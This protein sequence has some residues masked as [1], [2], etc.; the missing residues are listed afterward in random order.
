MAATKFVH[1]NKVKNQLRFYREDGR[2]YYWDFG[3]KH[4]Y[5]DKAECWY[6]L[7]GK[8]ITKAPNGAIVFMRQTYNSLAVKQASGDLTDEEYK[9]MQY[10]ELVAL[11]RGHNHVHSIADY[12]NNPRY[13][14]GCD[15]YLLIMNVLESLANMGLKITYH[16]VHNQAR[17]NLVDVTYKFR[18]IIT[19]HMDADEDIDPKTVVKEFHK[20]YNNFMKRNPDAKEMYLLDIAKEM[21]YLKDKPLYDMGF[22]I[23]FIEALKDSYFTIEQIAKYSKFMLMCY[24]EWALSEEVRSIYS[25]GKISMCR[26]IVYN[27]K[28]TIKYCERMDYMPRKSC[29][30]KK[31]IEHI[32]EMYRLWCVREDAKSLKELN[33]EQ[34]L[35]E[36]DELM[37]TLPTCAQ[38]LIDCGNELNNCVG[39]FGYWEKMVRNHTCVIVFV[40]R[41]SDPD[42]HYVC[43]EITR[44]HANNLRI[45]QFYT[46]NNARPRDCDEFL[47]N[48]ID[49]LDTLNVED[50]KLIF[51]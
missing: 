44:G 41:K 43:C 5:G 39:R 50:T 29:D 30:V 27:L 38:D 28:D 36:D 8:P 15:W 26:T 33:L 20:V 10:L 13:T 14:L 45:N 1:I 49:Y 17:K 2:Y 21:R 19:R 16:K 35:F 3:A 34:Y 40:K 32:E 11:L 7:S 31:E 9:M 37:V 47:R 48:Y 42:K 22:T 51:W 18:E 25:I 4:P 46:T 6:G 12:Y 23:E 24:N